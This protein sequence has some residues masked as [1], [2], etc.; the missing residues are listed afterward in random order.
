MVFATQQILEIRQL[1]LAQRIKVSLKEARENKVELEQ[2]P[3]A[4]PAHAPLVDR[5]TARATIMSLIL[6]IA[7]VGL[8]PF[9]H[10][11]TQFMI[12]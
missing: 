11:S 3:T 6:P 5:H 2:S 8:S 7:R 12:E 10:T 9:G 1:I 4:L